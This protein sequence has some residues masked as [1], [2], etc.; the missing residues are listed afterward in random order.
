MTSRKHENYICI[1]SPNKFE[2]WGNVNACILG[3]CIWEWYYKFPWRQHSIWSQVN[4]AHCIKTYQMFIFK[5]FHWIIV[6]G[7]TKS[8]WNIWNT[9]FL[10]HPTLICVLRVI[11]QH[12]NKILAQDSDTWHLITFSTLT[13]VFSGWD[14]KILSEKTS[15]PFFFWHPPLFGF[16]I[17]ILSP[18]ING[19]F[20]PSG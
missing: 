18:G 5:K 12:I 11:T 13:L 1:C 10:L 6:G 3:T 15:A 4:N 8:N 7:V 2:S 20:L 17:M 19:I 9:G 16:C 14:N